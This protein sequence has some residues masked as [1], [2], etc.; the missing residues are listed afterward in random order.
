MFSADWLFRHFTKAKC[1]AQEQQYLSII[2]QGLRE[3]W[4][5]TKALMLYLD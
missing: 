3:P 4:V 5:M 1:I 2:S